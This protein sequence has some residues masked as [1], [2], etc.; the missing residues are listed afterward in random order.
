MP[1]EIGKWMKLSKLNL[2]IVAILGTLMRYKIGFEF[3]YLD[4]KFTQHAHS[5]FAF[6]A[7]ITQ[8]IML[9]MIGFLEQ[10]QLL[11]NQKRYK[12]ILWA[13]TI[14]G[15]GMLFSFI[16]GG[17]SPLA[18][19]FSQ[20]SIF[21]F[22]IFAYQ[23]YTDIKH[24]SKKHPSFIWFKAALFFGM[25]SSLGTYCLAYMMA[26]HHV[27]QNLYL[28][29]VYFYLHFQYNGWFLFACIGLLISAIRKFVPDFQLSQRSFY[30]LAG[31]CIPAYLLSV[32]WL[33]FPVYLLIFIFIAA[34]AQ[35]TAW[36]EILRS[37]IAAF[38]LFK[39]K[40]HRFGQLLLL[41]IAMA[42]TVK[43]SLQLGS[44]IPAVSKLAFGFRPIVIAYLHLI[45]LAIISMFLLVYYKSFL[46]PSPTK[47]S[48]LALMVF[49]LGVY[50]NEIGLTIQGIAS[51]SYTV[52][53]LMNEML[54][55]FTLIILIGSVWIFL[56]TQR[57]EV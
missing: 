27:I 51:F 23:F 53:P 38:K 5:H 43:L 55:G 9:F 12:F 28:G 37:V 54:F 17:Y 41:F 22:Y 2:L 29:S 11:F 7:W 47:R 31:A 52:V 33:N 50:L 13:N 19:V 48:W 56:E 3:K 30:L 44:T 8:T 21:T 35:M 4:Q 57:K 26:T 42:Y 15:Y 24:T 34:A 16:Q 45:L 1:T 39:E 25:F 10:Q 6:A 49:A 20:L 36:I 18:I 40:I 14:T 32:L 46:V